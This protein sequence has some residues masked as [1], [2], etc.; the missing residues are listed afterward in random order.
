MMTRTLSAA[1]ALGLFFSAGAANAVTAN[2]TQTTLD[3]IAVGD[4][5]TFELST[6]DDF[7]TFN[8]FDANLTY[9]ADVLS[10]DSVEYGPI[11][12]VPSS[13]PVVEPADASGETTLGRFIAG[14]FTSDPEDLP[15]GANLVATFNFQAVGA[16][17]FTVLASAFQGTFFGDENGQPL[18]VDPVST[19]VT[20]GDGDG[21]VSA[22]PLPASA[23]LLLTGVAGLSV[24][25]LR[26][27]G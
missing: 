17:T 8:G 26:R 14:A 23:L 22:V 21:P 27:K 3:P 25:R 12:N 18:G 10:F 24:F 11:F 9:D 2:L 19:S 6:S 7:P 5:V 4:T 15:S 1:A 20:V 13:V 16:G